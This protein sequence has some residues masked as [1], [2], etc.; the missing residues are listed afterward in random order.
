[1]GS[2]HFLWCLVGR[3]LS[4]SGRQ[5]NWDKLILE[6]IVDELVPHR[7]RYLIPSTLMHLNDLFPFIP[8]TK[9]ER[10]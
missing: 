2:S 6:K 4:A 5:E 10:G 9:H 8:L 7:S 1:M 3:R